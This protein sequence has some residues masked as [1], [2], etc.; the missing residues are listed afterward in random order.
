MSTPV[1]ASQG[2]AMLGEMVVHNLLLLSLGGRLVWQQQAEVVGTL[3]EETD[4]LIH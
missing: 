2:T 4:V 1:L 3:G